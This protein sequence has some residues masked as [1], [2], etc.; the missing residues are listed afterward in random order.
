MVEL[1]L[2][3]DSE[4]EWDWLV[5]TVCILS[6]D[7]EMKFW[8][9]KRTILVTKKIKIVKT[10]P[11]ERPDRSRTQRYITYI[12]WKSRWGCVPD[13]CR[14]RLR[15]QYMRLDRAGKIPHWNLIKKCSF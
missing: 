8:I 1:M 6:K 15:K 13:S 4:K 2:S 5:Q 11:L 7:T 3:K 10:V 14:E 12:L 9:K